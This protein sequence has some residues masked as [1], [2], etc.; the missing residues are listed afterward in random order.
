MGKS[1]KNI[2]YLISCF[3]LFNVA[4][5]AQ[6]STNQLNF[7]SIKKGISKTAVSTIIQ[8]NYGFIWMGTNGTGLYRFDGIEYTSYS[9]KLNDSTSISN[10]I[11][12]CSY[13]DSKN[14]L[15]VGTESGLNLYNR[16]LD[17]F[18]KVEFCAPQ[19]IDDANVSV[20]SIIED[21]EGNIIVGTYEKGLF[22]LSSDGKKH[23][24][25]PFLDKHKRAEI[26]NINSLQKSDNGKIY[27]GTSI[28]LKEYDSKKGFLKPATFKSV[29]GNFNF[30]EGV[31]SLMIDEENN[32]WIG[33]LT[34]GL[35][36]IEINKLQQL[37]SLKHIPISKNRILSML[38]LATNTFLFG[39]ENDGLFQLN[40]KGEK[41]NV[42]LHDKTDKNSIQS[43][44]IW[45]L[46]L[47]KNKR[48]WAGFYSSGTAVYDKL[49]DK[50][51]NIESLS[52]NLNSL[53]IG[54]VTGIVKD[55]T[56]K[57]WISM[58]GGGIDIFDPKTNKFIKVNAKSNSFISGLTI[59]DIQT[60]FIDSKQNVWVGSWR[61]GL[62]LLKKGANKF[63]NYNVENTNNN[64]SSNSILSFA[65]DTKGTIWIG[66]FYGGIHSYDP[67]LN[68]FS[69][70]D[71]EAFEE[72]NLPTSA[73]RKVLVDSKDQVWIGTTTGLFKISKKNKDSYAVESLNEKMFKAH[74]EATNSNHILS[75]F[76]SS[77]GLIW[78]GTRGTG[79]YSYNQKTKSINWFN[80]TN[81]LLEEN[82]S[83][84]I[85]S[86][87]GNIWISGNSGLTRLETKSNTITNFTSDDGLLSNDFNFNAVFRDDNGT[88]YFGNYN[89]VDFFNPT[90]IQINKSK[91][92]LYLTDFKIF[93]KQVKPNQKDSPLKKV[94]S[95]TKGISLKHNQSVFTIEYVG[96]N[97]TRPE[98]NQYA[99][100]LEGFEKDWN[101]VGNN[102][103]ATYT[104]LPQGNYIFKVK[105]ANN[106]GVWNEVPLELKITILPPWWK[107]NWAYIIYLMLFVGVIY[108]V[109]NFIHNRMNEKQLIK[110][111]R[112]KR[113]QEE[114]LNEKKLQ[115]FTNISHEFRT[116]L[117]LIM[118][119]LEDIIQAKDSNL[120]AVFKQK[121]QIIYKNADRLSRLINELMDFRKLELNK[122]RIKATKIELIDFAKDIVA[123]FQDEISSKNIFLNFEANVSKLNVWADTG[124]LE[125]I[126][127]NILSN[128]F[129]VTPDNGS[130]TVCIS[131]K[132]KLEILPLI[133]ENNPVKVFEISIKDTG[134]GLEKD[135]LS[136]IFERFYQVDSLNG[137]YYGGT[138][139]GLE[140]VRS[141]VELHRGKIEVDSTLGEGT[142]F[143]VILPTG[144]EHF[145]EKEIVIPNSSLKNIQKEKFIPPAI[146]ESTGSVESK[147]TAEL[148]TLLIVEDNT[149]LLNY[150]KKELGSSYKI[151]T[152][153]NGKKG[154]ELAQKASPDIIITDVIMP[155]MDGFELCVKIK[156]DIRISHIPILMLTTKTMTDDWVEGIESGADAYMSK[157][158]SLRIL[159]S[160]LNQL[161]KNRELLFNKYFSAISDNSNNQTTTSLDK[162]FIQKVLNYINDNLSDPELSVEV[163]ASQL[164]LS[165]SQFYRK[166]KT[167][168]GYTANGFLRKIRL[169]KAKLMIEQ[170]NTNISDV[171]YSVGFSSPSYFTKCF[172]EHFDI[173][174][175]DVIVQN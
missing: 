135:Q 77:N 122:A 168:T 152:A 44:S 8:D 87:D 129:K 100:Y 147:D 174:P 53:E 119:P 51:E 65:E 136:K 43:N 75:L 26:F 41:I 50:F 161:I 148:Q 92:S 25:I 109:N 9:H 10:S 117:T 24:K 137:S 144:K 63:I 73:V 34:N 19:D 37:V 140:V 64:L 48:V 157:P 89:G 69:K 15:W 72:F 149:E 108:F 74:Q 158:F 17:Q 57:L 123:F 162:D 2:G 95:E 130:I 113:I 79:L 46:F 97:Y 160:R 82:V 110:N 84:I 71:S 101:Y 153:N 142:I 156:N 81:G 23:Q 104:N 112:E 6:D 151:L 88:V 33:T 154:L 111:E 45:S 18:K 139:I 14:R 94:I 16:D 90:K 7:V 105:A 67:K 116:P 99:Y 167:L 68:K 150:L 141:F 36:K 127:F 56:G 163:L 121:H 146:E 76:E 125:K 83:S 42:Y 38:Q 13:V 173:L 159:K 30:N 134:P 5:W 70:Y 107:T 55:N 114:E 120:P 21:A 131:K 126:I 61:N 59:N 91:P 138:G 80:K 165:R 39:T 155:E 132:N 175:T 85:E 31:Q 133:D 12:F 124:M 86:L 118:N 47:D 145:N 93:N 20:G 164:H 35:F 28:G 171:C 103:S 128:A 172:K 11:V 66:S 49:Y 143:R 78:I 52:T 96:V 58:D 1:F 27:V 60:I 102:R 62:F 29:N 98:K 4:I 166:I 115:F 22:K 54:S 106:D 3:W 170:G 32:F 169:Q 40:A